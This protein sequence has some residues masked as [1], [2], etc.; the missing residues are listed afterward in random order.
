[1]QEIILRCLQF[2]ITH[3]EIDELQAMVNKWVDDYE[4]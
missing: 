2:E 1:M 3:A 4:M